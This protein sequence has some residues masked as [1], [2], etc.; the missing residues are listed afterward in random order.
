LYIYEAARGG[1]AASRW[2]DKGA[3]DWSVRSFM[4]HLYRS[5]DPFAVVVAA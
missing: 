5:L 3:I 1:R 4:K 2:K